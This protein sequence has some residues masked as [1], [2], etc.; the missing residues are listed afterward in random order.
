MHRLGWAGSHP[1]SEPPNRMKTPLKL[2]LVIVAAVVLAIGLSGCIQTTTTAPDG[3][4]TTTKAP[5]PGV[6][7]FGADVV[8]AYSPREIKRV[9]EEKSGRITM[10]EIRERWQPVYGPALP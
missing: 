5:A 3:S 8:R 6:L 7:Q 1:E 2:L 4:V 10:R 9:R